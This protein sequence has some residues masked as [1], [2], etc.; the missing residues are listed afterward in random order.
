MQL[1]SSMCDL[2]SIYHLHYKLCNKV[3]LQT[4]ICVLMV[5]VAQQKPLRWHVAGS[6]ATLVPNVGPPQPG[7]GRGRAA[8][9]HAGAAS[10]CD[11]HPPLTP[12]LD[13][14]DGRQ[15]SNRQEQPSA[16]GSPWSQLAAAQ[17]Q[18]HLCQDR[19]SSPWLK[20]A[21]TR[22]VP[23]PS[24]GEVPPQSSCRASS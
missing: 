2:S 3:L 17:A 13:G 22:P 12:F 19:A 14:S 24:S 9:R 4:S 1:A 18:P 5:G 11:R 6:T 16:A 15:W 8:R 7:K 21:I 20:V 10:R 23:G